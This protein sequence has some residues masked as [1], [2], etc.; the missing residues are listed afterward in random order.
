[1]P[2]KV[3]G[4]N[5]ESKFT[6]AAWLLVKAAPRPQFMLS[7]SDGMQFGN[8]YIGLYVISKGDSSQPRIGFI[9]NKDRGKCRFNEEWGFD[10]MEM[11]W[12]HFAVIVDGCNLQVN[13]LRVDIFVGVIF[14]NPMVR[15]FPVAFAS[16]A[17]KLFVTHVTNVSLTSFQL[18]SHLSV[19]V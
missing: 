4:L 15:N 1:M 17:V 14:P 12:R 7:W 18:W 5:W 10:E 2:K 11:R 16:F 6:I 13:A 3:V 8:T 9:M 19:S